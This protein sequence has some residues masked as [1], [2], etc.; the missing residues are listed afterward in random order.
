M[1]VNMMATAAADPTAQAARRGLVHELGPRIRD[2]GEKV[3]VVGWMSGTGRIDGTSPFGNGDDGVVELGYVARA[4]ATLV[5]GGEVLLAAG[6]AYA[7]A[8]LIRQLVEMEY[9]AWSF[10]HRPDVAGEWLRSTREERR[11]FWQPAR[12]REAA[13]DRFDAAEYWRHCDLGGH[14]TPDGVRALLG[15]SVDSETM[16]EL[17]WHELCLHGVRLWQQI[18]IAMKSHDVT[19]DDPERTIESR[20]QHWRDTDHLAAEIRAAG[21]EPTRAE[22][23]PFSDG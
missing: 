6:N 5:E 13:D 14:P 8:A 19:L 11:A 3:H 21:P 12:L 22:P 4:A 17:Q 1:L 18:A 10:G 20:I 2:V 7:A 23:L 9:L 15:G 16:L